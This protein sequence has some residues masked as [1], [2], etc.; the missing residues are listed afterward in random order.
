MI[1]ALD[2]R[3]L[4]VAALAGELDGGT[5]EFRT[6]GNA[7]VATLT[8][9]DPAFGSPSNG[10]VIANPIGSDTNAAG[11]T[12]SK[13]IFKSSGND[14]VF[15]A[16]VTVTGGGGDIQGASVVIAPNETVS[17]SSLTLTQPAT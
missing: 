3:N 5:I 4:L 15:E 12:I 7:V 11:G 1:L 16:S 13:A 8:L 14:T 2:S 9:D 17:I 10:S 6:A